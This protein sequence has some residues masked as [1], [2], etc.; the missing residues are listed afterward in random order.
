MQLPNFYVQVTKDESTPDPEYA[1]KKELLRL[2]FIFGD[3]HL[4]GYRSK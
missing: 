3:F 4:E 1:F 2:Y